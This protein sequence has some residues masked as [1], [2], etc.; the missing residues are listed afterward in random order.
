M[1]QTPMANRRTVG[2]FGEVNAGKSSL[3]NAILGQEAAIVSDREGTT[4]D[5][6]IKAMELI[7]FGPISLMDT[8]GL[9]DTTS[10]AAL[11][12]NATHKALMRADFA[13]YA[14]DFRS[15]DKKTYA[16]TVASFQKY[17]IPHLLV[18][19]KG[20]SLDASALEAL[21]QE[22]PQSLLADAQAPETI[23]ALKA[24]V[25]QALAKLKDSEESLLGGVLPPSSTVAL[26]C[27]IDSAAP[28]GRL[29][30]PQVQLIRDCLDHQY[31]C[32]VTTTELL[33]E[34]IRDTPK[35]D[36]T[37]TDSQ[38][39][40]EVSALLPPDMALTSFSII[41]A[42]QKGDLA[43]FF[44][45]VQRIQNLRSG[46]KVLIAEA[47]THSRTHEDIGTVKIPAIL[48]KLSGAKLEIQFSAGNE[49][50]ADLDTFALIVHCGACMITK[51]AMR[52]RI[53]QAEDAG[54]P[55]TNYGM[56]LAMAA[57]VLERSTAIF[58]KELH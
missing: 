9:N 53:L 27:P 25:A 3:F 32:I 18:F 56:V 38:V 12:M 5:P 54:V 28:A 35:I 42:R 55:I 17:N 26:V 1:Q 57:G 58:E 39:F 20:Q 15:F 49:Y 46:D 37:V 43:R 33:P 29:I 16:E 31:K 19:M 47:C 14:A 36:L 2:I 45:G 34:V 23:N 7:P 30:L 21:R 40:G 44:E 13:L 6:V 50:P 51:K 4:T 11:R 41:M 22:F 10:I 8:A 48:Q 24:Q 52:S